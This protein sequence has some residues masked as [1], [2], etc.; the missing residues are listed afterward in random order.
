MNAVLAFLL[1]TRCTLRLE[2]ADGMT[3]EPTFPRRL[4]YPALLTRLAEQ[5]V[6]SGTERQDFPTPR[7]VAGLGSDGPV[8]GCWARTEGAAVR[9]TTI[10]A[11]ALVTPAR[12]RWHI[13][14]SILTESLRK[15]PVTPP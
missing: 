15:T 11:L 7:A 2:D 4:Q 3:T 12:S 1:I 13:G 5:A 14:K 6:T 9:H 10:V 8:A